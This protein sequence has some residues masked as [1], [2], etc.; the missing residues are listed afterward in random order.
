M[1]PILKLLLFFT[2][3]GIVCIAGY[4]AYRYFNEKINGSRTLPELLLY[5]LLLIVINISILLLGM[6]ALVKVY[7]MVS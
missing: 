7:E 2:L 4:M 3:T 6:L 1:L 5:T